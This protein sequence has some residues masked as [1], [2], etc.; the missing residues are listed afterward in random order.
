MSARIFRS[1]S[2]SVT[3][4]SSVSFNSRSARSAQHLLR[5][6][7][8]RAEHA[9]DLAAFVAD[10]RIGEREPGLLVVALPVHDERKVLAVGG[11]TG[12]CRVDQ[13]ADVRPDLG[14]DVVEPLAQRT[15]V[16]GAED[17]RVGVVVEE[18]QLRAPRDEHR[19]PRL[20]QQADHRAQ[21][22]RPGFGRAERRGGPVV[23]THQRA[24]ASPAGQEL[25]GLRHRPTTN[26]SPAGARRRRGSGGDADRSGTSSGA[27]AR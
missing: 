22:L 3:R 27:R 6:F 15:R 21:R 12:H 8:A 25:E 7:R 11:L 16:L 14:P 18:A 5:R 4:R 2:A 9:G 19:K 20:Q 23:R 1:A 26:A 13:R 17:F 10:G 24:D